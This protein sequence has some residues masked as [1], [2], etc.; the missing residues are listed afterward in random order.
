MKK[1]LCFDLD[2]TILDSTESYLIA[3][4]E[5]FRKNK[6]GFVS[7][8]ELKTL[9][10]ENVENIIKHFFPDISSRKLESCV[11]DFEDLIEKHFDKVKVF[12]GVESTLK[13]LKLKY[14]LAIVS[15]NDKHRIIE[16]LESSGL[17][18]E[19]FDIIIG[20]DSV[21][22]KTKPHPD[23]IFKAEKI[24]NEKAEYIIGDSIYD[25][26]AGKKAN[27]KTIAVLSGYNSIKKL[28][29]ENPTIIISN[30]QELN[31]IL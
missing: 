26:R 29:A 5:C 13:K 4:N 28:W 20:A 18:F 6:L 3:L 14:K 22:Q 31:S 9:Y 25:I 17:G 30:I 16:M 21:K 2:G 11:L 19:H 23:E 27:I 7:S 1:L 15:N 8:E 12:D 24:A 10:G